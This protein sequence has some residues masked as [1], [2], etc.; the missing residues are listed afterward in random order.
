[1]ASSVKVG[2]V[3]GTKIRLHVTLLLFMLLLAA[4]LYRQGGWQAAASGILFFALL[5][6]CVVVHE[7]GHIL[8]A[9]AFGV[10][11]PEI[12]LLPIG[13]MAR[14]ERIPE[15]PRE[16]LLMALAGPAASLALAGVLILILGGLPTMQEAF[17]ASDGR[18]LLAQLAYAN[19]TLL[20][21]NL[22]PAFPMD[23]GRVLRALLSA[24]LGRS[25]GT[26][27]AAA[28]GQGAAVLLGTAGLL[29]GHVILVLIAAFVYFAAASEVGLL[30]LRE[31]VSGLPASELM[32]SAFEALP[33]DASLQQAADALIRTSQTDLPVVDESGRLLGILTRDRLIAGLSQ[34]GAGAPAAKLM[35]RE[36]PCVTPWHRFDDVARFLRDGAPA[37]AVTDPNGRLV[38]LITR[39]NL[40]ELILLQEAR[41]RHVRTAA[42]RVRRPMAAPALGPSKV[43]F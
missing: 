24:R 3:G 34:H 1:M 14:L 27:I 35:E 32:V 41:S 25:R 31:A 40:L 6:L 13:G 38:G 5:F 11:T 42:R 28:I 36:V 17:A 12:L 37:A 19:L 7:F 26:R 22:M 33:A 2:A 16:E 23:G 30:R 8:A 20:V 21:F 9:R 18:A 4:L 29:I 39:E 10:R 43:G 15:R